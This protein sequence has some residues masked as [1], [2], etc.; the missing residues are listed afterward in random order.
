[1][2]TKK[3]TETVVEIPAIDIRETIIHIEGDTPLIT[4]KWSEKA[5][6]EMLEKQQKVAKTKTKDAKDPM[7]DFIDTIYWLEGEPEEKTYEGFCRALENGARIGFPA[8]AFKACAIMGAYRAGAGIPATVMRGAF[9]IPCELIEIKGEI[10]MREDMVKI[11]GISKTADIRYRAEIKN[12]SADIPVRYN[13]GIL[14]LEQV[15]NIF[16]LG[17]FACGVGEWRVE[18]NGVFGS[19]H[20][21]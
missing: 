14:T 8:T 3:N 12:W 19:Y 16:N 9:H 4:H 5:K 17:G 2:T 20:V 13:A 21:V 1:M 10:N 18:K 6:K 15:T 7:A 11:G